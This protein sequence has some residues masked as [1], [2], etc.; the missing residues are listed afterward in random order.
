[1]GSGFESLA[2]HDPHAIQ[3]N[4]GVAE[5]ADAQDLGSCRPSLWRFESSRPHG[6]RTGGWMPACSGTVGTASPQAPSRVA[7][8]RDAHIERK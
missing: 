4:A 1:M 3:V 8:A 6:R 7:E 2:A 5:L